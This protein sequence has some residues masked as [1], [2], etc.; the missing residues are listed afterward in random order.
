[1]ANFAA[2]REFI[3]Q[4]QGRGVD[5]RNLGFVEPL[6]QWGNNPNANHQLIPVGQDHRLE[7][8][9]RQGEMANFQ[10]LRVRQEEQGRLAANNLNFRGEEAGRAAGN[11]NLRAEEAQRA[12]A[13]QNLRAEE[14]GRAA[15]NQNLR[16]EEAQRALFRNE[17]PRSP[18]ASAGNPRFESQGL[19]VPP[20]HP[21]GQATFRPQ[22]G[23]Q[24]AEVPTISHREAQ[25]IRQPEP[26]PGLERP[27]R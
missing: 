13:N 25:P 21:Q 24:H 17:M 4:Q 20:A 2:Q 15:G 23:P 27:R 7:L 16:A 1:L 26:R 3:N 12:L 9:R 10:R 11:P 6:H 19:G 18:I 22:F 14:A 8:E 5:V